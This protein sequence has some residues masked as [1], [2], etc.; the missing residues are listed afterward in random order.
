VKVGAD[1]IVRNMDFA[2]AE[3]LADRLAP[4]TPQGLQ[5]TLKQLPKQAQ[6]IVTA[7]QQQLQQANQAIQHLQLEL[8]YKGGIAQMQEQA[9]TQRHVLTEQTKRADIATE[10]QTKLHDTHVKA[11]ASIAVAEIGAAGSIL[12]K[13]VDGKYDAEAAKQALKKGENQSKET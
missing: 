3:D 4:M 10:S 6:G 8:K 9:E 13:H 12:G 11:Q 2:G 7:M 5:Q 1:L